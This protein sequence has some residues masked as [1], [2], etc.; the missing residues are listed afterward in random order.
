MLGRKFHFIFT[1]EDRE[2]GAPDR[3]LEIA[4]REGRA[5]NLRWHLC[6][7]GGRFWANG[8]ISALYDAAGKPDGFVKIARDLTRE[9]KAKEELQAL[10]ETLEQR[11]AK[12]T[13][14]LEAGN[15]ALRQSEA[16]FSQAFY[17]NPIPAC[18]T[19]TGT[20]RFVQTNGAFTELTGYTSEETVG[21]TNTELAMWAS[22]EDTAKLEAAT[23]GKGGFRD[24]ELHLKTK[25]G[26]ARTIL[27]SAALIR[28]DGGE[29]WLK[30]FYD[31]T[32]RKQNEE[33]LHQAIREVMSDTAWFS[34]QVMERLARVRS[35]A[36]DLKPMVELTNRERQVLGYVAKGLNN[37]QIAKELNLATQTVRNY[38]AVV[39]D[40]LGVNSRAEAVVWARTRGIVG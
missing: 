9:R 37:Q 19:T 13:A 16:R 21:R 39:Y 2:E 4:R 20:E 34:Q 22:R 3:E 14:E 36:T 26:E 6:K 5:L 25:A 24:L 28:L 1:P 35:G 11:V 29:G 8:V 38:I 15:E 27:G 23:E 33:Q 12:R 32:E 40:K 30:L 10:N 17:L 18:L 31:I 7:D